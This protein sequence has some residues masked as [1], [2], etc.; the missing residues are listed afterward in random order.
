[1]RAGNIKIPESEGEI[2]LASGDWNSIY[3]LLHEYAHFLQYYATTYGYLFH[4][5]FEK[6]LM[7]LDL[8]AGEG[9][10]GSN[11]LLR[12]APLLKSEQAHPVYQWLVPAAQHFKQTSDA[13]GGLGRFP[14]YRTA[15][16][17]LDSDRAI[18]AALEIFDA[19]F[20]YVYFVCRAPD[21][22]HFK[23]HEPS[24]ISMIK[25]FSNRKVLESHAHAVAYLWAYDILTSLRRYQEAQALQD[26]FE[27]NAVGPYEPFRLLFRHL[28]S[29][30]ATLVY[31]ILCDVALNPAIPTTHRTLCAS[32]YFEP[33][34]RLARYAR[35]SFQNHIPSRET[36]DFAE[37]QHRVVETLR[38]VLDDEGTSDVTLRLP[39]LVNAD[40]DMFAD[41]RAFDSLLAL[42]SDSVEK[43]GEG[44]HYVRPLQRWSGEYY[45]TART[46]AVL[47]QGRPL[48]LGGAT[49]GDVID[50]A[51]KL[52]WPTLVISHEKGRMLI[53]RVSLV[54]A[55]DSQWFSGYSG[56][57]R[58]ARIGLHVAD[59]ITMLDRVGGMNAGGIL[60]NPLDHSPE[61]PEQVFRRFALD[62]DTAAGGVPIMPKWPEILRRAW[63]DH[64]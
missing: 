2:R 13:L 62:Y 12:R 49:K 35:S 9:Y 5:T 8:L 18:Q 28:S 16:G 46:A 64:D 57:S 34:A 36:T 17:E 37:W 26:F 40:L 15:S 23:D 7:C 31:C 44:N 6:Y 27:V 61:S 50:A 63:G 3:T 24:A 51:N 56:E 55:R 29:R 47:R 21:D 38:E 52:G 53:P 54:D 22:E 11:D 42:T 20:P 41:S 30:E 4:A 32:S 19:P 58:K 25:R 48:L 1:M 10:A 45:R 39:Q 33:A 60:S 59:C 14:D 43:M